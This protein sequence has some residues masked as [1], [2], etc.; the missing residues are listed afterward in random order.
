MTRAFA[1][2]AVLLTAAWIV[3][4]G[5]PYIAAFVLLVN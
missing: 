5:A 1:I 2:I 3:G 4:P